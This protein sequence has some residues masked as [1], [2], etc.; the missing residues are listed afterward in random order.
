MNRLLPIDVDSQEF[1]FTSLSPNE[2]FPSHYS[3]LSAFERLIFIFVCMHKL[4]M[5]HMI[6]C[7]RERSVQY[8]IS[9]HTLL[10]GWTREKELNA[11]WTAFG[12]V[13]YL[14]FSC[15]IC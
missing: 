2:V 12:G 13:G 6:H 9:M 3:Q 7:D 11:S 1:Y 5:S 10:T 15:H 8:R 4:V 14:L